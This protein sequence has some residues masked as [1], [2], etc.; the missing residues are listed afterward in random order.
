MPTGVASTKHTLTWWIASTTNV[1]LNYDFEMVMSAAVANTKK[2]QLATCAKI[3]ASTNYMCAGMMVVGTSTANS[4]RFEFK[5]WS[6]TTAPASFTADQDFDHASNFNSAPYIKEFYAKSDDNKTTT[7]PQSSTTTGW[8]WNAK[9]A[10]SASTGAGNKFSTDGKTI[11]GSLQYLSTETNGTLATAVGTDIK[12]AIG[13][14][15]TGAYTDHT[16]ASG[17]YANLA[18]VEVA[19][20]AAAASTI[21]TGSFVFF[22]AA[23]AVALAM[24]F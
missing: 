16:S 21:T 23:A 8:L 2:Y 14:T 20:A 10:W 15:W 5:A 18:L 22:A 11:N 1:F 3:L 12:A 19:A 4:G 7:G 9:F 6:S 13:T 17:K 24:A